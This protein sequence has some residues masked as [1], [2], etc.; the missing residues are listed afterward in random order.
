MIEKKGIMAK[1]TKNG[2]TGRFVLVAEGLG[3]KKQHISFK[4]TRLA[5]WV[6]I[7]VCVRDK[8]LKAKYAF[9]CNFLLK[10]D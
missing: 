5:H 9:Q 1:Q 7:G 10:S 8:I 4:I 2:S 3:L 6:G